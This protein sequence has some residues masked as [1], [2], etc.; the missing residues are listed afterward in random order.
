M[1]IQFSTPF[2]ASPE[3]SQSEASHVISQSEASSSVTV[4]YG[5]KPDALHSTVDAIESTTFADGGDEKYTQV[6]HVGVMDALKP[7]TVY[8]YKVG[9]TVG[10]EAGNEANGCTCWSDTFSY[11]TAPDA[12]TLP[13]EFPLKFGIWGD[14]GFANS[15][16]LKSVTAEVEGGAFDMILHV[17]DF[18]YDMHSD[19]GH[20]G[21]D[22]MNAIQ[23][24]ASRVPYM[25]DVGNHEQ[26]QNFAHYTERFRNLPISTN[27][28]VLTDN[29]IAPNNWY[30][31]HAY[32][33]VLFIAI[34]T[35][36]LFVQNKQAREHVKLQYEFIENELKN[37][38]R[39]VTPWI[40]VHGHRPMYC[41]CDTDCDFGAHMVRTNGY[42]L[43]GKY[44]LEELFHKYGVDFYIAG[45]E[46]K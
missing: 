26:E 41:S 15:Q 7:S 37:A 2:V 24:L 22:F 28:T 33:N 30:Y 17:G 23:P 13:G 9:H 19:N 36:I 42:V 34:S 32:G 6:N 46:H 1:S 3:A 45:H 4:L 16:I 27:T 35:E 21:D 12:K 39:A 11:K 20:T 5:L 18:A 25:V 29:G 44:D 31:S 10:N 8:Y 40:V 38:D 43:H 14:M